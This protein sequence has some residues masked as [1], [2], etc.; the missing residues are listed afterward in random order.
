MGQ[1]KVVVS[2]RV[3]RQ[4]LTHVECII[5]VSIPAAKRFRNEY[6]RILDELEENPLQFPLD[7]DPNLPENIYHK[8]VF[9]KWY[10]A[11]FMINANNQIVYLDAIV[12]CRQGSN[13]FEI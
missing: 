13:S 12:D 10:K 2:S 5:R 8:A 3:T 11:L 7:T 6:A 4:L 1:Y 9:V